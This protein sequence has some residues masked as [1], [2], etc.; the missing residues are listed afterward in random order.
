MA[1]VSVDRAFPLLFTKKESNKGK[2]ARIA[3][4]GGNFPSNPTVTVRIPM[5]GNDIHF[6]T[7]GT[8]VH[9]AE[10]LFITVRRKESDNTG[11]AAPANPPARKA[12]IQTGDLIVTIDG[13][14]YLLP[15]AVAY[16]DDVPT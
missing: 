7:V 6:E 2:R 13:T 9:T 8:V 3:I 15:G 11:P 4:H 1:G 5:G 12:I 14:E 16:T 10:L